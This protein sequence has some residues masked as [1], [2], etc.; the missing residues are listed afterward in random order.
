M[1][2][3]LLN[4]LGNYYLAAGALEQ[5]GAVHE[6]ALKIREGYG[7]HRAISEVVDESRPDRRC[8]GRYR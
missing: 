5:A 4:S 2:S 8:A 3:S 6:E 7:N 1:R